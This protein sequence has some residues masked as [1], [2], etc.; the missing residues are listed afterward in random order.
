MYMKLTGWNGIRGRIYGILNI[1]LKN[2]RYSCNVINPSFSF[3]HPR[4]PW[5]KSESDVPLKSYQ[6]YN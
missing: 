1:Y 3:P 4:N 2:D 6:K 5:I